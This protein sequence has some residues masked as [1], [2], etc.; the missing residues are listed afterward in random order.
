MFYISI[1]TPF[2]TTDIPIA[3]EC[4]LSF[5]RGETDRKQREASPRNKKAPRKLT[6]CFLGAYIFSNTKS[7]KPN[8]MVNLLFFIAKEFL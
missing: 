8:A 4:L 3:K 1:N 6:K 7:G 5:V 2:K